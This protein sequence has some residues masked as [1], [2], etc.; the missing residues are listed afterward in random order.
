MHRKTQDSEQD[1]CYFTLP[2]SIKIW[3]VYCFLHKRKAVAF[4]SFGDGV[5][6]LIPGSFTLSHICLSVEIFLNVHTLLL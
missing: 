5:L 1:L 6:L 4:P 2:S 3:Y